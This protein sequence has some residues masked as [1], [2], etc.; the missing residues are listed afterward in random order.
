MS[1]GDFP[2]KGLRFV[3]AFLLI[4]WAVLFVSGAPIAAQTAGENSGQ[5]T[6]AASDITAD[7][8]FELSENDA[9]QTNLTDSSVSTEWTAAGDVSILIS[10]PQDI[11]SL[12]IE[13]ARV[14]AAWTL[15]VW[16]GS[17]YF[18]YKVGGREGFLN[19]FA[20]L[21]ASCSKI[22]I[23]WKQGENPASIGRITIFSDGKVPGDVQQWDPPCKKAD[24]LVMP[25]HMDDEHLYF[26]GTMPV[27]AAQG[28]NVQVAYLI[29]CGL[30]RTREALAGLWTVGITNYPIVS[31]FPDQYAGSLEEAEAFYGYQNILEYQTALLRRFKPDVIVGHDLNGEYGHGAHC[32]NAKTLTEAAAAADDPQRFPESAQKYGTWGIQKLYLHLYAQNPIVMDWT[33]PM[34][35]LGGK[36]GWDMAKLGYDKH[37]SQHVFKFRVRI[38]GPNDCRLFGL[39]YTAVGPD[40]AKND[41]FENVKTA[42]P[43]PSPS[44]FPSKAPSGSADSTASSAPAA[45]GPSG[46]SDP[47]PGGSNAV[48]MAGTASAVAVTVFLLAFVVSKRRKS[49]IRRK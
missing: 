2:R 29:D 18:F 36:S 49:R 48:R 24:L 43:S 20:S 31:D 25:T 35:E 5:Q 19:E 47:Q 41:F 45:S 6:K 11:G 12:Y 26:G 42:D 34:E 39:Y 46:A 21:S 17:R 33:A 16:D 7:C 13:W 38:E 44:P 40:V 3:A 14:P 8:T 27:Y 32:L 15:S 9:A 30:L 22:R 10:A 37:V 23:S 4:A 1:R 28:K